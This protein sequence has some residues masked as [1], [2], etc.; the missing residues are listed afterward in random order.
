MATNGIWKISTRLDQ[1]IKY[2][3][4]IEKVSLSNDYASLHNLDEYKDSSYSTEEQLFV[5]GI[6][7]NAN[8]A[9][10][11]MMITKKRFSKA[12]GILGFHSFQSFKEGEVTPV[13]AHEIGVKLAQEM[14][15][16]RFEV[17]VS[18]HINTNHIH[19]HFVINSVSFEDGKRYYD[20]RQTYAELRHLSNSICEEYHLS[21]L[22]EMKCK[23]G[24][25]YANYYNG[26]VKKE[27]YHSLTKSDIDYAIGQAYS[28]Y[29]FEKILKAMGY[30]LI[31]RADKLSVRKS[32]YKKNIRLVRSYGE[33]YSIE[34]ITKRIK[35]ENIKRDAIPI[36][37]HKNNRYQTNKKKNY[38]NLSKIYIH[39][40][41]LLKV[42]PKKYP[43]KKVSPKIRADVKRMDMLSKEMKLLVREKI[44]TYEQFFLYREKILNELDSLKDVRS[45]LWYKHKRASTEEEKNEIR[46]QI[47]IINKKIK[48]LKEELSLCNDIKER[49]DKMIKN[50]E[51]NDKEI[52]DEREMVK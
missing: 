21:T 8:T 2:I 19:N 48:P 10:Q 40:N 13:I 24:I 20:T 32:P 44:K 11:E 33:N 46:S 31:Y 12:N 14:W 22:K 3:T 27:T 50:L 15:G 37:K 43:Y 49:S 1:V 6:N 25:N 34:K 41:Y 30:E 18:T 52:T 51:E 5:T 26:V 23:S 28:Y 42:Y 4:N 9:Y 35:E 7:C 47:S 16:D 36:S 38:N 29:D 17:V 39:Y 45:K